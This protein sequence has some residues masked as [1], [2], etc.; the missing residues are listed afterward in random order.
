[1]EALYY[2]DVLFAK[3]A[4]RD[5]VSSY[6]SAAHGD[7]LFTGAHKW[8]DA[9]RPLVLLESALYDLE[10]GHVPAMLRPRDVG[11]GHPASWHQ[12]KLR[13]YAAGSWAG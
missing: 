3:S 8:R 13:G 7:P 10:H 11:D 12:T 9:S 5:R 2:Q 4:D 1:M 6:Q